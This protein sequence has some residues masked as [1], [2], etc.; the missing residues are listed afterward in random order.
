MKRTGAILLILFAAPACHQS[1]ASLGAPTSVTSP[2]NNLA[3]CEK[4]SNDASILTRTLYWAGFPG[5]KISEV[6]LYLTSKDTTGDFVARVD[7]VVNG[8]TAG[9]VTGSV[10]LTQDVDSFFAFVLTNAVNV[11][12]GANV[13]FEVTKVS[14]SGDLSY[15]GQTSAGCELVTTS[16]SSSTDQIVGPKIPIRVLGQ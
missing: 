14:G 11:A 7:I 5:T 10:S 12:A 9:S 6:D 16:N 4:T 1:F 2:G 8:S 3:H 13:R 15:G